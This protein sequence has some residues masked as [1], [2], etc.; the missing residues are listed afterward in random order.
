MRLDKQVRIAIHE[1]TLPDFDEQRIGLPWSLLLI[2]ER[3]M[4]GGMFGMPRS[5]EMLEDTDNYCD[6]GAPGWQRPTASSARRTEGDAWFNERVAT[7][8]CHSL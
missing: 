5:G 2:R 6:D 3:Q 7:P 8:A 4:P 1:A